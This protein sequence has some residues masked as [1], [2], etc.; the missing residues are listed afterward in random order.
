MSDFTVRA[1]MTSTPLTIS[2]KENLQRARMLMRTAKVSEVL[3][4]DEGKLVGTLSERDIW[5]RC[6]TSAVVLDE[7]QTDE[8]LQHIRVGGVMTLHPPTLTPDTSVREAAQLFAASGR[9][10][11]PAV[12]DGALVGVLTQ[13][14]VLQVLA[15]FVEEVERRTTGR[16]EEPH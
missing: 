9:Q 8:L 14:R 10:G 7:R 16:R 1:W 4:V 15:A 12:E 13:D 5:E 3:V 2:P 11:L 6:P